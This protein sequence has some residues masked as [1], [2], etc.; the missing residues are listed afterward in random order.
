MC[1][2]VR[3]KRDGNG[4]G[5]GNEKALGN[6]KLFGKH[7]SICKCGYVGNRGIRARCSSVQECEGGRVCRI[8]KPG[9]RGETG[10]GGGAVEQ[11]TWPRFCF[12]FEVTK[13]PRESIVVQAEIKES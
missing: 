1:A 6:V 8:G 7:L 4:G 2:F 11:T 13:S 10:E 9:K 5:L 12:G 3:N